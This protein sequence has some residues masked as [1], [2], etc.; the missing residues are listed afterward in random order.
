MPDNLSKNIPEYGEKEPAP[1]PYIAY[2]TSLASEREHSRRLFWLV[3]ALIIALVATNLSWLYVWQQYDYVSETYTQDGGGVNFIC[4][5]D[6]TY[7]AEISEEE[8]NP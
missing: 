5:G 2:E 8:T 6:G 3:V 4:G 1:V 7:G